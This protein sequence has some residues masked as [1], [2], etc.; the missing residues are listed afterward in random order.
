LRRFVVVCALAG[1][2]LGWFSLAAA[3]VRDAP[4]GATARCSDGTY[5]FSTT[6]SGTCS[7]HGGVAVWLTPSGGGSGGSTGGGSSGSGTVQVKIGSTVLLSARTKTSGCTVGAEPDR[8]CSP[9]AYYSGLTKT[10]LCSSSFHTSS[11]R[12]VSQATKHAVEAEYG[13]ATRAYGSSLEIDHVVPLETGGSNLIA[14]LF[15]EKVDAYPGYRLKDKLENA[16]HAWVCQGKIGL[17]DAQRKIAT[18]WEAFYTL[19][20]GAAAVG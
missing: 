2:A 17:R 19:V 15:P 5:S 10:V 16:A 3:A 13:L 18:D 7:H 6:R 12:N 4:P 8:R 20:F 1:F 11:I 14:N 9:G